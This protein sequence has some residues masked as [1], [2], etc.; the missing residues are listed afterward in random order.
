MTRY[1]HKFLRKNGTISHGLEVAFHTNVTLEKN[2]PEA[3]Q[4][5]FQNKLKFTT[6]PIELDY[7]LEKGMNVNIIDVRAK[8]DYDKS[9]VPGAV[10]LPEDD[11]SSLRGLSSD[12][13]NVLYCY[14]QVC[15]LAARAGAFF[16]GRGFS[17]MELEGGFEG[18]KDHELLVESSVVEEDSSRRAG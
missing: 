8:K 13:L 3:A 18:W 7:A 12:R 9:H 1:Y 2:D 5:Y 14:S 16:A 11:W 15:H 10:S 6:G 17:V 4:V